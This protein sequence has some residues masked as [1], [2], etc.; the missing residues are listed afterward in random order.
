MAARYAVRCL[1]ARRIVVVHYL[2]EYGRPLAEIAR[3]TLTKEEAEIVAF[4]GIS[5][6]V[7]RFPEIVSLI[8]KEC[9]DLVYLALTEIESSSL[10][11]Q[12]RAAGVRSLLFGTDGSREV[13]VRDPRSRG[14]RGLVSF[15]RGS[16]P[17]DH[18]HRP[19]FC[20][21]LSDTLWSPSRLWRGGLRWRKSSHRCLAPR[22][23]GP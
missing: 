9:P 17:A 1:G 8:Q 13:Q 22:H 18:V 2:T 5:V 14:G 7:T 15:L 11:V 16:R 21:A 20:P 19:S 6:G 4:E 10:A 23:N 12:L 3:D